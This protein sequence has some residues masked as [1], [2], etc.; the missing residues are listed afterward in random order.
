M[1]LPLHAMNSVDTVKYLAESQVQ[2][3]ALVLA[4]WE[5]ADAPLPGTEKDLETLTRSLS[6]LG[7]EV[8]PGKNFRNQEELVH[9]Y[10]NPFL[11]KVNPGDFVVI[12]FSG[13][14]VSLGSENYPVP[15]KLPK[16]IREDSFSKY[17]V[18]VEEF[19]R[20]LAL[21]QPG[22][23]F[24]ILDACREFT[25]PEI[26]GADGKEQ[27]L[28]KG[29]IA[30]ASRM[31]T[32][33]ALVYAA[34]PGKRAVIRGDQSIFTRAL[35][36]T[37]NLGLNEY[38]EVKREVNSRVLDASSERQLPWY[39]ESPTAVIW[40]KETEETL[41]TAKT[42]WTNALSSGLPENVRRFRRQFPVSR[43]ATAAT[44]WL[45]DFPEGTAVATSPLPPQV[46][47]QAW[48]RPLEDGKFALADISAHYKFERKGVDTAVNW[49]VFESPGNE[50]RSA[51]A[52]MMAAS[53]WM[54]TS[55]PQTMRSFPSTEASVVATLP[56]GAKFTVT[57]IT[58]DTFG[59]SWIRASVP[60]VDAEVFMEPP[61][62]KTKPT[63]SIVGMPVAEALIAADLPSANTLV[64]SIDVYKLIA[65]AKSTNKQISW[66]SIEAGPNLCP[67]GGDKCPEEGEKL[68][69]RI[70]HTETLLVN[71]GLSRG[72]VT[73]LTSVA[74]VPT[75]KIRLRLF[76]EQ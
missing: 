61:R 32:N 26:V 51:I 7:F 66:A 50:S 74:D 59:R 65:S 17:F 38:N 56:R 11:S 25:G 75:G 30:P 21:R 15:T 39:S 43:Y 35:V 60:T 58:Y 6:S 49:S 1:S 9:K 52:S 71:S 53:P 8:T 40:F 44:E 33:M 62:P 41:R 42:S 36:E 3:L 19:N 73:A 37:L 64:R 2:R 76:Q 46:L 13:H 34:E 14:G 47:R 45:R 22:I 70:L 27:M 67:T 24:V 10:L 4:N 54:Q 29:L 68:A 18:S 28:D 72:K 23:S 69:M 5:Y 63:V 31:T 48:E 55:R 16:K 57:G 12:Y 20:K